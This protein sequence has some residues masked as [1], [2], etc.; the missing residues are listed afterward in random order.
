MAIRNPMELQ[1][2]VPRG[3]RL[4]GLDLGSKT[5][6]LAVSDPGFTVASPIGTIRRTKF[7]Q[8]ARELAR[9]PEPRPLAPG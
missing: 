4:L 3:R 8:D 9:S 5:I 7:T 1:A 2:L 6:G